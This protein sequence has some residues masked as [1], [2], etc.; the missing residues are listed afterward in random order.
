MENE[1]Y[2]DMRDTENLERLRNHSDASL[3]D[4]VAL[5]GDNIALENYHIVKGLANTKTQGS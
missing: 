1:I 5:S 4:L 3:V 2:E